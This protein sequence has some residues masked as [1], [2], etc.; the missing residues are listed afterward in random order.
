MAPAEMYKTLFYECYES[1]LLDRVGYFRTSEVFS[2]V[3]EDDEPR[4]VEP[5]AS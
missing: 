3:S 1:S 4:G 5:K 2:S